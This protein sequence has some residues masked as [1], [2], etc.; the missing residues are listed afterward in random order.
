MFE[1]PDVLLF[2]AN[3]EKTF[4]RIRWNKVFESAENDSYESEA[5]TDFY[6]A[7]TN[8]FDG[9]RIASCGLPF[10][11]RVCIPEYADEETEARLTLCRSKLVEA[12]QKH[13]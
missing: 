6:D 7:E 11:K 1:K 12:V 2:K 9:Q 4:N 10:N 3:I 5:S 13:T 8:T